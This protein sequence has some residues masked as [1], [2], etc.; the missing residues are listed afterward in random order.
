M[1]IYAYRCEHC[2][3][4]KDVLQKLSDAPPVCPECGQGAMC[5]Q[6]TT[7]AF[8]LKGSGWYKTDFAGQGCPAASGQKAE[9]ISGDTAPCGAPACACAASG[10]HDAA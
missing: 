4:E 6:V 7:A 9:S 3:F 10:Q 5:K 2:G 8:D 1:P